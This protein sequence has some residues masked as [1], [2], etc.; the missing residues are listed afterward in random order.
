VDLHPFRTGR[1]DIIE[2]GIELVAVLDKGTDVLL[3]IPPRRSLLRSDAR[4]A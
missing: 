4:Q 1:A 2:L 3:G